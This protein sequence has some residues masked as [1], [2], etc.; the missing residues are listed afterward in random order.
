MPSNLRETPILTLNK[1]SE[2]RSTRGTNLAPK[3]ANVSLDIYVILVTINY[4]FASRTKNFRLPT[5]LL[6]KVGLYY[7]FQR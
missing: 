1:L 2:K 3:T 5:I 6:N 7:L 4:T